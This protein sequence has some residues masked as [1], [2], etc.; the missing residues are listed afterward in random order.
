MSARRRRRLVDF[1]A[2]EPPAIPGSAVRIALLAV[3]LGVGAAAPPALASSTPEYRVPQSPLLSLAGSNTAAQRSLADLGDFNGD[4]VDDIAVGSPYATALGRADAGRVVILPVTAAGAFPLGGD[5]AG[6]LNLVG[7]LRFRIGRELAAVGDVNGDGLADLL[8]GAPR[9]GVAGPKTPG[10]AFL[11][12]G[13]RNAGTLD[14][15]APTAGYG[16]E[17]KGIT[18]DA[19]SSPQGLA[20][21]GDMTGD[22][23]ADLVVIGGEYVRGSFRYRKGIYLIR[24]AASSG[25]VDLQSLPAARG[26]KLISVPGPAVPAVAA[27][28]RVNADARPDLIVSAPQV[29]VPGYRW[30]VNSAFVLFTQATLRT[31]TLPSVGSA[32]FRIS[33]LDGPGYLTAPIAGL[34]DVNGDG[35]GDVGLVTDTGGGGA[36][37]RPR[38]SVIFGSGSATTISA[39]SPGARGFA[40]RSAVS[41]LAATRMYDSIAAAGDVNGDGRGDLAIH[42]L[43]GPFG[44]EMSG[45]VVIVPGRAAVGSI[46]PGSPLDLGSLVAPALSVRSPSAPEQCSAMDFGRSFVAIPPSRSATGGTL[47]AGTVAGSP[48]CVSRVAMFPL[49][50]S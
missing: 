5:I 42:E 18:A 23:L 25:A 20:G 33:G 9:K 15:S 4:G 19:Y 29:K 7:G 31:V 21:P 11:V 24:G 39:T 44:G 36:G 14:L 40:I 47:L 22:G 38:A 43:D 34:G 32:G 30:P 27:A 50:V 2:V 35:L 37:D 1:G 12:Y 17:I 6:A 13:R 46:V 16:Y 10:S 8:V 41:T 45:S 49:P 28:G 48:S 3:L 26:L